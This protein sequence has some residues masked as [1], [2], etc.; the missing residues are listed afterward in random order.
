[1]KL[2]IEEGKLISRAL[3]VLTNNIRY[4]LRDKP[5]ELEKEIYAVEELN[6]KLKVALIREL[7]DAGEKIDGV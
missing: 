1:M 5:T 3:T 2:T 7:T 4:S 6:I